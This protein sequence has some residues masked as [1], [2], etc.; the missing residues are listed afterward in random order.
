M[1]GINVVMPIENEMANPEHFLGCP[2]VLNITMLL[3]A[4]L[5]GTVGLLGYL[6]YGDDALGSIT[7]NLPQDEM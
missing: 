2:G 6:K 7:L 4:M 1:E 3:V 5:Y